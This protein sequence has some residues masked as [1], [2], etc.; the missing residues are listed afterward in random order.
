MWE[1][2]GLRLVSLNCPGRCG[3]RRAGSELFSA[4]LK[5]FFI[6]RE[7][8]LAAL[9]YHALYFVM[10]TRD[11]VNAYKF[12]NPASRSSTSVGCRLHST[13]VAAHK[14]RDVPG[15]DVFLADKL[16]I[17]SLYHC[18]RCFDSPDKTFCLDHSEC[19]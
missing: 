6:R 3:A 1:L 7:T 9:R 15:A 16:N 5:C 13:D 14:D 11:D 4:A 2:A 17:C 18:I 8:C 10:R 12:A 19:L